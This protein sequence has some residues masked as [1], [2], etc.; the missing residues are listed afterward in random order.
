MIRVSGSAA[1]VLLLLV[2]GFAIRRNAQ[3]T[4]VDRFDLGTPLAKKD[5]LDAR[6]ARSAPFLPQV[7]RQSRG[8]QLDLAASARLTAAG[9]FGCIGY[10]AERRAA[11]REARRYD[12]RSRAL[13]IVDTETH[14]A[15]RDF[16]SSIEVSR[17]SKFRA[18]I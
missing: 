7:H 9:R 15:Q 11:L 8:D 10:F 4:R 6:C 5:Y 17:R 2:A 3:T 14:L 18:S 16:A 12:E 13:P 1:L